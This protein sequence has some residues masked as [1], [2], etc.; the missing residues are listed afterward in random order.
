MAL[1]LS[2]ADVERCLTMPEAI[3]VMRNA[4]VALHQGQAEMPPRL[5]VNLS[6]EGVALMM[7]SLLQTIDQSIFSLKV[8]TVMPRN[9]SRKLP[10]S[11]ATLLVVDST[12]G[13]TLAILDGTWLTAMRTGAVSGLATDILAL[14]NANILALFGAGGQAPTQVLAIHTVRPLQEIRVVNRNEEHYRTLVATLHTLLGATCPPI[15]RARSAR[16]ALTGATLVACATTAT[17]PLFQW[18]DLAVG[19]HINA[20]GAFTPAMREVDAET[21]MR[22]RV[23]VDQRAAALEEAGDLLQGVEKGRGPETWSEL[24]ELVAGARPGRQSETEVTLF[25]SVGVGVQDSAVALHVY[26]RARE[27]NIGIDVEL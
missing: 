6:E 17:E 14:R 25:K 11:Y 15:Q 2:R 16:E 1:I 9:P 12:T 3:G 5:S 10:L 23:V 21:V 24:G 8:I 7:P 18:S 13:R 26:R 27:L 20:I 22:A 19:T 4:F